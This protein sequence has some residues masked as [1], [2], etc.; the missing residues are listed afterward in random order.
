M[1]TALTNPVVDL[2]RHRAELLRHCQRMLG[3]GFE[4][5]DAVQ[6]TLL[7]AWRGVGGFEGRSSLRSWLHRIATNVCLDMRAA[8][9][10]RARPMDM[11]ALEQSPLDVRVSGADAARDA[12]EIA[13]AR[14][15][16]QLAIVAALR[17]LPPRQR[18]VLILREVLRWSADEVALLLDTTRASVNSLLQRA[19]AT[20]ASERSAP[21]TTAEDLDPAELALLRR[22]VRAFERHDVEGLT[23]LLRTDARSADP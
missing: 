21:G 23:A 9:E 11:A 20:L 22:Y 17:R 3:S 18:S 6:E 19:R 13:L 5:E 12:G 10:R 15:A 7:R 2:E 16:V 4:A 8:G 14:E 1:P